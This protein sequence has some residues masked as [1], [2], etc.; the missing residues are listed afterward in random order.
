MGKKGPNRL[1]V[2]ETRLNRASGPG[3]ATADAGRSITKEIVPNIKDSTA[4]RANHDVPGHQPRSRSGR[5]GMAVD[6]QVRPVQ[7]EAE[8]VAGPPATASP[9]RRTL[10][11]DRPNT[12]IAKFTRWRPVSGRVFWPEPGV[13]RDPPHPG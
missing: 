7:D 13:L 9:S 4:L 3:C 5:K 1:K 8:T 6:H 2:Q 10:T 12:I 11:T